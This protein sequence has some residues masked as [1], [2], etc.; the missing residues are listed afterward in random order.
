VR[1]RLNYKGRSW[2]SVKVELAPPEKVN[3]VSVRYQVAQKLHAC[4]EVFHQGP[5]NERF[6]DVMDILLVEDLL[7]DEVGLAATR[8][9]CVDIF[10]VRA[11]HAWPPS[12]TVYESWRGPFRALADENGFR[13][14]DI[15][16]AV[17]QLRNLIADITAA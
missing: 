1:V 10:T 8:E 6:R 3:C 4:T 12:V 5:E 16:R 15:D 9:A 7:R 2:G 14:G 13:P 17:E 11:K